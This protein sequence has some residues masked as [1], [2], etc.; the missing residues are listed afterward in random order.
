MKNYSVDLDIAKELKDNGFPQKSFNEWVYVKALS[1]NKKGYTYIWNF[2]RALHEKVKK[3][4]SAP[5]SDEILK[6][7][8]KKIHFNNYLLNVEIKSELRQGAPKSGNIEEFWEIFYDIT[9]RCYYHGDSF[10]NNEIIND[11]KLSNALAKTWL[12]LKKNGYL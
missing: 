1:N 7:L 12:Y 8:P 11:K 5:I 10:F 4:I 9:Y 2:G 6:E 3:T